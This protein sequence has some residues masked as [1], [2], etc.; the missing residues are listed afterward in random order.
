MPWLLS[1]QGRR[2]QGGM[3]LVQPHL[4]FLQTPLLT[5]GEF[6]LKG[7]SCLRPHTRDMA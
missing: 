6:S 4:V 3:L 5:E 7:W 1:A 2:E